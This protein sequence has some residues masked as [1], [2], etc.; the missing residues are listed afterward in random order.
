MNLKGQDHTPLASKMK[1]CKGEFCVE[2]AMESLFVAESKDNMRVALKV[3][4]LVL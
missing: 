3:M 4:P 2:E 1:L